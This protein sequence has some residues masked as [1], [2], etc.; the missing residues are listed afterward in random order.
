MPQNASIENL[1][2]AKT[3]FFTGLFYGPD[4]FFSFTFSIVKAVKDTIITMLR[5]LSSKKQ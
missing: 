1:G 3:G 2:V 4:I 5:H